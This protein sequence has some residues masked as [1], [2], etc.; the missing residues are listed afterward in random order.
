MRNLKTETRNRKTFYV[1]SDFGEFAYGRPAG[2][3]ADKASAVQDAR[4]RVKDGERAWVLDVDLK[5]VW[6][7]AIKVT[8]N[9]VAMGEFWRMK[10]FNTRP[11]WVAGEMR[12]KKK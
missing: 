6:G 9:R 10:E 2:K 5:V 8:R 12:R 4:R 7:T 11:H 1:K 3:F